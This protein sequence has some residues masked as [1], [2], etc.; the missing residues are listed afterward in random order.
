MIS[1]QSVARNFKNDSALKSVDKKVWPVPK[2]VNYVV[3]NEIIFG[4]MVFR[5]S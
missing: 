5:L 4:L 1:L 2:T 3:I